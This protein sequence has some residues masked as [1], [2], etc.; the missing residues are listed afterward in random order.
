MF[1][2]PSRKRGEGL[3]QPLLSVVSTSPPRPGLTMPIGMHVRT[4]PLA[5]QRQRGTSPGRKPLP[6]RPLVGAL[7]QQAATRQRDK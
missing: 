3:H 4:Q 5:P 2:P 6:S 1:P 7:Q